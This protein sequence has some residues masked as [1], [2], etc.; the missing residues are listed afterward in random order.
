M[1]KFYMDPKYH[2]VV[3][4]MEHELKLYLKKMVV[5]FVWPQGKHY[6]YYGEKCDAEIKIKTLI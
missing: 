4:Q 5:W 2:N 3:N 1:W 6:N